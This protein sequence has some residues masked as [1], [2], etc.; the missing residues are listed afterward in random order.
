MDYNRLFVAYPQLPVPH[1]SALKTTE[2]TIKPGDT[3]EGTF[4]SAFLMD[5]AQWDK[6]A[7][8]TFSLALQYQKKLLLEPKTPVTEL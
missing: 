6:H 8:L 7:K 3:V 2:L 1:G 4:V 5:K